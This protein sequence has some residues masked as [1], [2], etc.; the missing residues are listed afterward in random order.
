VA[1]KW[2]EHHRRH[3]RQLYDSCHRRLR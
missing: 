2:C 1:E 3:F